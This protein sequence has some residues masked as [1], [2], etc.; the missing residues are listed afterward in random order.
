MKDF[1]LLMH[2][3]TTSPER[4]EDWEAY[5]G[6]LIEVG[7]FQGGSSIGH[8]QAFRKQGDAAPRTHELTGYIKIQA[9]SLEA[10]RAALAG[11]PTFEAGGTVEIRELVVS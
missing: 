10:A 7:V 8:G 11:N 4:E 6:R 3:D 9:E 5:I 1:I 2:A